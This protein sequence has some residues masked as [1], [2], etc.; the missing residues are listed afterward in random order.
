MH[1]DLEAG[2]SIAIL[3]TRADGQTT[4]R[5]IDVEEVYYSR[6]RVGYCR[7]FC[8]L[9][10][11]ERTFRLDRVR[12]TRPAATGRGP[13]SRAPQ[14]VAGAAPRTAV[15]P[16]ST[17]PRSGPRASTLH[18]SRGGYVL[19]AF[20]A[21]TLKIALGGIVDTSGHL[22]DL[23]F[24]PTTTALVRSAEEQADGAGGGSAAG[25]DT[26]G[27]EHTAADLELHYRGELI[28]SRRVGVARRYVVPT[29]GRDFSSLHTARLALNTHRFTAATG[30]TDQALL[31]MFASADQNHDGE[32]G[33]DE[34]ERFQRD[35]NRRFSYRRNDIALTPE[36]FRAAGGGDCEDWAFVTCELLRFWDIQCFIGS[37]RPPAGGAGHA[38]AMV[39]A[40]RVPPGYTYY[41]VPADASPG[42]AG[43][44][45]GRYVPVDYH[46]VGEL[47][48]AVG[49]DWR[50]T[51]MGRAGES[52]G[53]RM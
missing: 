13:R 24:T 16:R 48:S 25:A 15:P 27:H 43:I 39:R 41:E 21:V 11:E 23:D 12:A 50:L 9:R 51:R 8:R 10:G 37:F 40:A 29:L 38:V 1:S 6:A 22:P 47:S 31:S 34:L 42:F 7:A 28:V 3:Y 49:A 2:E 36:Q 46:L 52:Y 33:W 4:W 30:F 14:A 53:R 18:R 45:A 5:D 19:A 35:I 44:P 17:G 32:L 26:G 20:I